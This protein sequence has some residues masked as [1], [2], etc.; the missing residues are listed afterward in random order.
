MT[1]LLEGLITLIA[2]LSSQHISAV[3][4]GLSTFV[5]C[6]QVNVHGCNVLGPI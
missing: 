3:R 5:I 2:Y 6:K 1:S 4:I